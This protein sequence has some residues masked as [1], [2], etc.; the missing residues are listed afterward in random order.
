MFVRD[1]ALTSLEKPFLLLPVWKVGID[2]ISYL[3]EKNILVCSN[4]RVSLR[5]MSFSLQ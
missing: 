2:Y 1:R 5:L 4:V 3:L